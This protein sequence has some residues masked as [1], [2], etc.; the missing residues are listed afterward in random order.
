MN[1]LFARRNL[2]ATF[3]LVFAGLLPLKSARG[4]GTAPTI[5]AQPHSQSV[6][7]GMNVT[8]RVSA[9]G[10]KSPLT[11]Q[12]RFNNDP[13]LDATNN[14]YTRV[15]VQPTDAGN[16]SVVVRNAFGSV[17]SSNAILTVNQSLLYWD[18]NGANPGPGGTAPS[19]SWTDPSWSSS[20]GG[21]ASTMNWVPR[22]TAFFSADTTA[23]DPYTISLDNDQILSGINFEEGRVTISGAGA[24]TLTG[25]G[26]ISVAANQTATISSVITGTGGLIKTGSGILRVGGAN[27]Y[28]GDTILSAGTLLLSRPDRIPDASAVTVFGGATLDLN[29]WDET[30]GSLAG[31]GLVNLSDGSLTVGANDLS[32]FFGGVITGFGDVFKIGAG[33]LTLAGAND[34]SDFYLKEGS[35]EIANDEA[36]SSRRIIVGSDFHEIISSV[37]DLNLN[38]RIVLEEGAVAK[39]SDPD[40][41]G[42]RLSGAISGA[43]SLLRGGDDS[44]LIVLSGANNFSGGVAIT[45]GRLELGNSSALGTGLFAI[46]E[47]NPGNPVVL[48]S[49]TDL[50]GEG[51]I[52]NPVSVTQGFT[53]ASAHEMEFSGPMLLN[54][55][56]QEIEILG[57]GLN[58][59]S[60]PV[61]H[62]ISG[63]ISGNNAQLVKSGPGTLTLNGAND[64]S[65][66]TIIRAGTLKVENFQGSATGGGP[67]TVGGASG[68]SIFPEGVLS[69]S[70]T[71]SGS[72]N[73]FGTIS[74]GSGPGQISTGSETW[75]S[76]GHYLWEINDA[77][78][79]EGGAAHDLINISDTLTINASTSQP[80]TID[81]S[82]LTSEGQLLN[83][84]EANSYAWRIARTTA[85]ISGFNP[86]ALRINASSLPVSHGTFS[87]ALAN[88]DLDLVLRYDPDTTLPTVGFTAPADNAH[89]TQPSIT[90]QGT[91]SDNLAVATVLYQIGQGPFLPANGTT[92]W[93]AEISLALGTNTITVK[94]VDTTGNESIPV[95]RTIILDST[96]QLTIEIVGVGSVRPNLNGQ[97]LVVGQSYTV[98]AVPGPT[99]A[100]SNWSGGVESSEAELTF[101]MQSNLLLRA[102]FVPASLTAGLY[103]GLFYENEIVRH[104]SSGFFTFRLSARGSFS[105]KILIDGGVHRISGRFNSNQV[106]HAQVV[107]EGKSTLNILLV[108]ELLSDQVSGEVTTPNWTATVLGDLAFASAPTGAAPQAGRYTMSIP[109]EDD[110]DDSTFVPLGDGY[111]TLTVSVR[112]RLRMTGRLPDNTRMS[113]FTSISKNGVWPFYR[114]LYQGK[115]SILG[116]ITFTNRPRSSLEGNLSWIK[117]GGA[118]GRLFSNGFTNPV[119]VFG[120]RYV[121]PDPGTRIVNFTQGL[122]RFQDGNLVERFS[123]PGVLSAQN[124]FSGTSESTH[125]LRLKFNLKRGYFRGSFIHPTTGR[126]TL[127][128]GVVLQQSE[129]ARGFFL[130]TDESGSVRVRSDEE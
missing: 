96:S 8:F 121:R 50:T 73:V 105:G 119:S 128:R 122:A 19:G 110:D 113:Q 29:D 10:R 41:G 43:G 125:H 100:F 63:T 95:S 85:G 70:G 97:L 24:L 42:F 47:G 115:G 116:W 55:S 77:A 51:S 129:E 22:S 76:R 52:A 82:P 93:S 60:A 126:K 4:Q 15:N 28:A 20:P 26:A 32:S 5:I 67:V 102:T 112:G 2:A 92:F 109:G 54:G 59:S 80:F 124:I 68:S 62:F 40:E 9:F 118:G 74:P 107:R 103:N 17:L 79:G 11:Y 31:L 49:T 94:S 39:L 38:N 120:S 36:L 65:G 87:L 1:S 44:G 58:G 111:G 6:T 78:G 127:V 56:S 81:I 37:P 18:I 75:N 53:I 30:I 89:T 61:P 46:S 90:I 14:S 72:V 69:G 27:D 86:G 117:T 21:T 45:G 12:W 83:F 99:N 23:T 57:F 25:D 101:V 114:S 98:T 16:Y 13:I 88:D 106:A 123:V 48:Q 84:D 34:F 130:G 104:E 7:V 35:V 71:I 3:V 33:T 64:Y 91:S 66:S 108:I